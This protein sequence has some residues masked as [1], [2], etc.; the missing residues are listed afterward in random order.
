VELRYDIT[1]VGQ[2]QIRAVIRGVEQEI[3]SSNKR[4]TSA[5]RGTG[6]GGAGG[7]RPRALGAGGAVSSATKDAERAAKASSL[8]QIREDKRVWAEKERNVRRFAQIEV[9][10]YEDVANKRLRAAEKE[11]KERSKL[12]QSV[13]N[14]AGRTVSGSIGGMARFGMGAA[15]LA[16]GLAIGS[17]LHDQMQV[18]AYASRVANQGQRPDMKGQLATQAQGLAGFTGEEALSALDQF[19]QKSGDLKAGVDAWQMIGKVSLATSS[20]I[21]EVGNAAGSAYNSIAQGTK[22]PI[23]RLKILKD[24]METLAVQGNIGSVEMRDFAAELPKLAA[25]SRRF[26]GDS[27]SSLK[28][29]GALT[30]LAVKKGGATDAAEAATSVMRFT[31]DLIK[32]G[33]TKKGKPGLDVFTDKTNTKLRDPA[34]IIADIMDKTGGDLTKIG[35]MFGMRGM[36]ALSGVSPAYMD[37]FNEAEKTKKGT[38]KA[39]GRTAIG[40]ALGEFTGAS[41]D[42]AELDKRAKLR[43][44]DPDLQIKEA[45]KA[46]NVAIGT[47]LMP[48]LTKLIPQFTALVPTVADMTAQL[49]AFVQF[50]S[51][52]PYAGIGAIIAGKITADLAQ[53]AIGEGVKKAM[54]TSLGMQGGL[55]IGS[56]VMTVMALEMIMASRE[57]DAN[58]R[59]NAMDKNEADIR[60]TARAE[61]DNTGRL[62]PE[63]KARLVAVKEQEERRIG[64]KQFNDPLKGV[65]APRELLNDFTFGLTGPT[66][67]N[68]QTVTNTVDHKRGEENSKALDATSALLDAAAAKLNLAAD[69]I[70]DASGKFRMGTS[71]PARTTPIVGRPPS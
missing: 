50:L 58:K 10:A 41:M 21:T 47:D 43:L 8:A 32:D 57:M 13:G 7:G 64:G 66:A 4:M 52:N 48:V 29:M 59:L 53:A 26:G 19:V 51:E 61:L 60:E 40:L 70:A 45:A 31:D 39:A 27:G 63:T 62:S 6:S 46:F 12:I 18:Q 22:D 9:R 68:E 3:L 16:G 30:Q 28:M 54:A 1:A 17:A 14:G 38:G 25:A 56:A 24:V 36:K 67:F 20:D 34:D 37:A 65:S 44:D 71:D 55:I 69:K 35:G 5:I 42:D 15:T 23:E 49:V 33:R 2:Q 11:A